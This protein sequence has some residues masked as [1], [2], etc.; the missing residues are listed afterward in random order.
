MHEG[1]EGKSACEEGGEKCMKGW[2]GK[3]HEGMEGKSA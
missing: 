3:V 2:R 1:I